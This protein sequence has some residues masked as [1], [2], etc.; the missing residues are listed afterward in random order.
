MRNPATTATT[1]Q[2]IRVASRPPSSGITGGSHG[3]RKT[4][5]RHT[6]CTSISQEAEEEA[7][8]G[9]VMAAAEARPGALLAGAAAGEAATAATA[10]V[11][12]PQSAAH[13]ATAEASRKENIIPMK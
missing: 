4:I 6:G 10:A 12:T 2:A 11:T 5:Q 1:L 7:S 9:P 3:S 8:L 13:T